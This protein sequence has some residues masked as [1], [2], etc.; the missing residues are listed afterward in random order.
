MGFEWYSVAD[1]RIKWLHTGE[2]S[3][4]EG[5]IK[6]AQAIDYNAESGD[7]G[8]RQRSWGTARTRKLLTVSER[9]LAS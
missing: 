9:K 8:T 4:N 2:T 1:I 7:F 6:R 5:V 3:L